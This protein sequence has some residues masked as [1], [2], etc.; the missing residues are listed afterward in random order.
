MTRRLLEQFWQQALDELAAVPVEAE[1]ALRTDQ[2]DNLVQVYDVTLTSLERVRIRGVYAVPIWPERG[3]LP[4]LVTFPGYGGDMVPQLAMAL[5]AGYA[6]LTLYPRGQGLSADLWRLPDGVTKLT[7]GLDQPGNHYYRAAYMDCVRAVDFLSSRDEV[8]AQRIGAYGTSQGGGLSLA[9][10]ALDKRVR[11]CAVHV[12]FLCAYRI[13]VETA[14]TGP[15]LELVDYFRQHPDDRPQALETLSFFDPLELAEW[16]ECPTLV[17]IGDVDTTCP[18]A[19]I[20][21]VYA[22]LRCLRALVRYPQLGHARHYDFRR[23]VRHWMD[24]YL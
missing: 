19:T 22:R 16:I 4:A 14:T 2:P 23:Q 7:L 12:P 5:E 24:T 8:D 21:A 6:V 15:Y 13:A 9:L 20:E 1:V 3:R 11:A 17:T 10:A 18:P